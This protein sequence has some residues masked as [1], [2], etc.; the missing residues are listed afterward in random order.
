VGRDLGSFFCLAVVD[1]GGF[2]GLAVA[3]GFVAGAV[4][5]IGMVHSNENSKDCMEDRI[6]ST[7]YGRIKSNGLLFYDIRRFQ[8]QD[9][10]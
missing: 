10:K 2:V 6:R 1:E 4:A 5:H 8:R 7:F 9:S 3:L